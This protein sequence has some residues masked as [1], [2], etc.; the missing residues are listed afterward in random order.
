MS[1]LMRQQQLLLEALFDWPPLDALRAIAPH[2]IDAGGRGMKV[3]QANGHMLAQRALQSAYPVLAQL[4]GPE[5]FADLARALWHAHPPMRGD[6]A[7]W[8]APLADFVRVSPQ[9][10]DEPYLPDVARAEWALHQCSTAVN[11]DPDWSTLALLTTHDPQHLRFTP[12]AG[13]AVVQS[14]WPVASILGAHLAQEP[15]LEVAGQQLRAAV[16]QD[17]VIWRQGLQP[18]VRASQCGE[19]GFL[20]AL[21]AGQTIGAA[22]DAAPSLDFETWLPL[23]VQTKLICS[24]HPA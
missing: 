14:P 15:S 7:Q 4:L 18:Q 13:F 2:I 16:A 6:I 10:Q 24:V 12:A 9:L 22:L 1:T 20:L 5:S 21:L 17:C 23:A 19:A 8:G 11:I 3:Y